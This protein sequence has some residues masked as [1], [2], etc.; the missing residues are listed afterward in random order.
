MKVG[1][2]AITFD[3]ADGEVSLRDIIT[4]RGDNFPPERS[5]YN[6]PNIAIT[7]DGRS[8]F[9]YPTGTS[10]DVQYEI[11]NRAAAGSTL[12][13]EVRIGD[14]PLSELTALY[15]I[16]IAPP[17]LEVNP[18][19]V[20]VG[21]PIEV[22]VSG[23]EAF[24]GGYSV[25]ITGGPRLVIDGER[26]F[27]TGRLGQFTGRSIIP[28]DYHEDV[29]TTSGRLITL[30]VHRGRT[31]IPGVF[32]SVTLQQQ[33]Y[34]APTPTPTITPIPTQYPGSHP[35]PVADGHTHTTYG[36]ARSTRQHTHATDPYTDSTTDRYPGSSAYG[37]SHGYPA[38]GYCRRH[39]LRR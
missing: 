8:Q 12:R 7:I 14:Y 30:K 32:G 29:A 10:W 38:D 18:P 36:Y 37:G 24:T 23:L 28:V 11:T 2:P 6:P 19:T 5:Y 17:E 3:P 20:R 9:V 27:A 35:H 22:S 26:T 21:Q 39:T 31:S 15:R 1:K 13:I 34:V 4:I 33:Q 16:K 25:E